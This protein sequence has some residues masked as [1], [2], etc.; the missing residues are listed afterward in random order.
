MSQAKGFDRR[1]ARTRRSLSEALISLSQEFGYERVS[2]RDLTERADVGYATFFRHFRS[3]DDLATYCVR[4]TSEEFM[5]AVQSAQTLHEESLALYQALNEHRDVCLFGLSLPRDHPALEPVWEEI[6]QWMMDLYFAR[7]GT[8]IPLELSLNHLI[9]SVVELFRWWLTDGQDY[10][11]EQMALMQSDLVVR[12]TET[13]AL[14][15]RLKS[16]RDVVP[17]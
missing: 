1:V 5:R 10:S 15:H 8:T 6:T 11:V 4:S 13:V 9:N 7:E 14:D 3:K 16:P 12:M 17:D 2:I